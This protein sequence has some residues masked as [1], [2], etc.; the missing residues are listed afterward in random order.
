MYQTYQIFV[1]LLR[2]D[3]QLMIMLILCVGLFWLKSNFA[4][5]AWFYLDLASLVV[6]GGLTVLGLIA[7]RTERKPIMIAFFVLVWFVP[8][9]LVVR[10]VVL[11]REHPIDWSNQNDIR[12][13]IQ[14]LT[15]V[16]GILA[17]LNRCLEMLWAIKAFRNFGQGLKERGMS[18]FFLLRA[19]TR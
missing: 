13:D 14:I 5:T 18:G 4:H 1:T 11:T 15:I 6:D 9:Y 12:R 16:I 17:L 3:L 10:A 2:L 19:Y 7:V 8:A